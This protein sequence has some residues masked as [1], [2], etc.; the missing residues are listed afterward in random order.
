MMRMLPIWT[1]AATALVMIACTPRKPT[2]TA[3]ELAGPSFA[4]DGTRVQ[5]LWN[6]RAANGVR[7]EPCL[8]PG[9]LL[10]ISV[11]RWPDIQNFRTRVTPAG[12]IG[13]PLLGAVRAAGLTETQLRDSIADGL[14]KGYMRDPQVS[15]FVAEYVSQQVS[16][17]GAVARPGLFGL[18]RE[19]RTVSDLISEAGGYDEHAGGRVLLYPAK[20]NACDG[21][22]R[23][24]NPNGTAGV[25][26][27]EI[28]TNEQY[29]ANQNPFTLP[30]VGG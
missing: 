27:V 14:R 16:V 28:D 8:G 29:A 9:D 1:V 12:T 30:V 10:E 17:T 7:T 23:R 13:L 11:F 15:V 2:P 3:H 19:H 26:P 5:A 22:Q 6:E 25:E 21:T 20:G 18:S 4:D 24:P